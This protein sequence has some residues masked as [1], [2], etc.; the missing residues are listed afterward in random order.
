MPHG[1]PWGFLLRV[2]LLFGY[3]FAIESA[4]NNKEKEGQVSTLVL[5]TLLAVALAIRMWT[6][7][8]G[9]YI[10]IWQVRWKVNFTPS[11]V[12]FLSS[13]R[14]R[15]RPSLHYLIKVIRK[16]TS[17]TVHEDDSC[18]ISCAVA[19]FLRARTSAG[20]TLLWAGYTGSLEARVQASNKERVYGL[21]HPNHKKHCSLKN[22]ICSSPITEN[23]GTV[24][25]PY[26][27]H[28]PSYFLRFFLRR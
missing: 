20:G 3:L 11:V 24:H 12:F 6:Y 15:H 25:H 10:M 18:T 23:T 2:G 21:V 9:K 5:S 1:S 8:Y 17:V 7:Y 19:S 4:S 22:T 14:W 28:F 16:N 27:H 26:Q 13:S